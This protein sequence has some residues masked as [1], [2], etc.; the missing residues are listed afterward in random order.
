[1]ITFEE[2]YELQQLLECD[3]IIIE[4]TTCTK[5]TGQQTSTRSD[6]KYM[7]C[8]KTKTGYKRVHY[9]DPNLRIKKSN[10]KRRK[11]FRAR[12]KC[13]QK[14]D[15]TSAGYWSCRNW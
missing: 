10:P 9:G 6:K 3:S 4:S 5:V 13:S 15:K 8:V 2:Y 7:R 11:S 14:K 1:M 12:H